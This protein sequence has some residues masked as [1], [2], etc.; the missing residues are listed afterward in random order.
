MCW[1]RSGK[2]NFSASFTVWGQGLSLPISNTQRQTTIYM[3]TA[4][5]S[6]M[7]ASHLYAFHSYYQFK[8]SILSFSLYKTREYVEIRDGSQKNAFKPFLDNIILFGR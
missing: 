4:Y 7:F 2:S 1:K 3:Y 5:F 8:N 6:V